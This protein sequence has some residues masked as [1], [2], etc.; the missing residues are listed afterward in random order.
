LDFSI[1]DFGFRIYTRAI[2]TMH[3]SE[4]VLAA[5]VLAG[6]AAVAAAGVAVGLKE[7]KPERIPGVAV[8]SSAFFVGSLIHI[9]VGPVSIHLMLNGVNGLILGWAAFPSILVALILQ[10]LL[11]QFGGVV[12][13]GANTAVMALPAVVVHYLFRGVVRGRSSGLAWMGG[14]AAGSTAVALGGLFIGGTLALSGEAF[15]EA[16]TVAVIAHIP[17][18]ISEGVLTAFCISFLRK[19]KPEILGISQSAGAVREGR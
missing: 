17:V 2:N 7:L 1:P 6:S 18:L 14:F 13:L 19:V 9:P 8:L 10:A 11:F 4:G 12:V 15:F 5:P 3:I 16:A